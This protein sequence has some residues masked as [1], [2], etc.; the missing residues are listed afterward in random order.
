M[1]KVVQNIVLSSSDI[2]LSGTRKNIDSSGILRFRNESWHVSHKEQTKPLT[3]SEDL[4]A[5][6]PLWGSYKAIQAESLTEVF[7]TDYN[8]FPLGQFLNKFLSMPMW[9]KSH[10]LY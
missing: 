7:L 6:C 2:E 5:K 4:R 8:Q 1:P 9:E 10:D 3:V